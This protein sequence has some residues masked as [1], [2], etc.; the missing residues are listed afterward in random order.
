MLNQYFS[1]HIRMVEVVGRE[2]TNLI[3]LLRAI[4]RQGRPRKETDGFKSSSQTNIFEY[5]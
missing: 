3:I 4:E 5:I 1:E 2:A